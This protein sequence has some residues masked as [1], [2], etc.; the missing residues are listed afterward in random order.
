MVA[1]PISLQ[2]RWVHIFHERRFQMPVPCHS[3]EMK[4][5]KT[6]NKDE[7]DKKYIAMISETISPR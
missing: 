5:N 3:N 7:K 1:I 4:I 6:E 2:N